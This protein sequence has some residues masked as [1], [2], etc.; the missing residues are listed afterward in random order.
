VIEERNNSTLD[1]GMLLI[2]ICAH[3][4]TSTSKHAR[5]LQWELKELNFEKKPA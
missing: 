1:P 3:C 4:I 5:A 2:F